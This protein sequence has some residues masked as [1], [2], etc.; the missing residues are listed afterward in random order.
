MNGKAARWYP[1]GRR[2]RNVTERRGLAN[3][4]ARNL[5]SIPGLEFSLS[6]H[7]IEGL[8]AGELHVYL[9]TRRK[10]VRNSTPKSSTP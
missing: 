5:Y 3:E 9:P 7:F 10:I 1:N 4:I 8:E 6:P 2:N